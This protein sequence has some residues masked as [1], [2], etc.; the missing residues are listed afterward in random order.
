MAY[1]IAWTP[2]MPAKERDRLRSIGG[3][4]KLSPGP[5]GSCIVPVPNEA[6]VSVVALWPSRQIVA[7]TDPPMPSTRYHLPLQT[8]DG[9]WSFHGG[10]WDRL[11]VGEWYEMDPTQVHGAVNW[12]STVR[13]H[14]MVDL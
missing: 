6:G 13:I 4:M 5:G 11:L 8:N 10:A 7:H 3:L 2:P 12:G 1:Q 14:L 9:C